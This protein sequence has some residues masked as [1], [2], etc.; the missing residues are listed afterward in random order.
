MK[1]L[2]ILL[3]AGLLSPAAATAQTASNAQSDHATKL[4]EAHAIIEVIFPPAQREAMLAKLQSDLLT[5][6]GT[7][8]PASVMAD[9]GLKAI[10]DDFKTNVLARQRAV[11]IKHMPLQIDAM[12]EAYSHE[13]SLAELKNI[14]AFAGSKS[15]A[16]YLS[17]SLSIVGDPAVAR[18]NSDAIV[19]LRTVTQELAPAF[20]EKVI[21]YLKAHPEVANKV[22]AAEKAK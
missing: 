6:M 4:G 9:P 2:C 18:A 1:R 17:K 13:F 21:A 19:E 20:Q 10:V 22:Q 14:H 8:F 11:M 15:G 3:A 16:H 7:T 12:A 5:Q